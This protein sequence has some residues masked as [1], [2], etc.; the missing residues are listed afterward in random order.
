MNDISPPALWDLAQA[1]QEALVD[2]TR[3]LVRVPSLP[4]R[5]GDLAALVQA[6]MVGYMAL[7]QQLG[8]G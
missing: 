1:H 7:I 3:R 5:E 4:G 6:G 8:A 2:F